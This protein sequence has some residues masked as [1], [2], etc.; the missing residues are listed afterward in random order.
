MRSLDRSRTRLDPD[1]RK[2][3]WGWKRRGS[4]DGD[5]GWPCGRRFSFRSYEDASTGGTFKGLT[6]PLLAGLELLITMVTGKVHSYF[7]GF[8][9]NGS[10]AGSTEV[11]CCSN[12]GPM[13]C[14]GDGCRGGVF[15]AHHEIS[16][17]AFHHPPLGP[18]GPLSPFKTKGPKGLK[19]LKGLK[20][21]QQY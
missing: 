13:G 14:R 6:G 8:T 16:L 19:G 2:G 1:R 15:Q 12:H 4:L 9:C 7:S 3:S 20:L 11:I 21:P 18:L 5:D 17:S 10:R